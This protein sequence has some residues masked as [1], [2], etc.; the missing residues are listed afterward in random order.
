[1]WLRRC[2]RP[3]LKA[4]EAISPPVFRQSENV[5]V[6][7]LESRFALQQTQNLCVSNA[8]WPDEHIAREDFTPHCS[9]ALEACSAWG[10]ILRCLAR[11]AVWGRSP[12]P[13]AADYRCHRHLYSIERSEV[14]RRTGQLCGKVLRIVGGFCGGL[15]RLRKS[16]LAAAGSYPQIHFRRIPQSRA[17]Q[18]TLP[19]LGRVKSRVAGSGTFRDEH[20]SDLLNSATLAARPTWTYAQSVIFSSHLEGINAVAPV[21]VHATCGLIMFLNSSSMLQ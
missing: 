10:G 9:G 16:A 13:H 4:P 1:M 6:D 12:S 3:H 15:V 8:S 21:L 2:L 17:I 20:F 14:K 19:R 5:F 18:F 11:H 7:S